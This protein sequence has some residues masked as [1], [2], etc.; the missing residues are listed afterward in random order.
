MAYVFKFNPKRNFYSDYLS[1]E[2][3]EMVFIEV[4]IREMTFEK[5][6]EKMMKLLKDNMEEEKT[7]K[8]TLQELFDTDDLATM[9]KGPNRD[10]WFDL[11]IQVNMHEREN[12]R[13]YTVLNH[14]EY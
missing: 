6:L 12:F 11:F 9:I 1:R 14:S 2:S 13:F 4:L 3:E 7:S 5:M 10:L 8:I